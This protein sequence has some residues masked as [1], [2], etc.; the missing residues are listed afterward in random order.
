M[1]SG[2]VKKQQSKSG[3][4]VVEQIAQEYFPVMKVRIPGRVEGMDEYADI[5]RESDEDYKRAVCAMDRLLET[6]NAAYPGVATFRSGKQYSDLGKPQ[7]ATPSVSSVDDGS[8]FWAQ[9]HNYAR[10]IIKGGP[11]SG[12]RGT[13]K[14]TGLLLAARSFMSEG[15]TVGILIN[16]DGCADYL[17]QLWRSLYGG[18]KMPVIAKYC[19]Q[20]RGLGV[21]VLLADNANHIANFSLLKE[22]FHAWVW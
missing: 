3:I 5:P 4:S 12:D 6:L 19:N 9:A 11:I 10:Q 22:R 14:T 8:K 13:G 2:A 16:N 1:E 17:R 7:E 18:E 21:D 15:K 20:F